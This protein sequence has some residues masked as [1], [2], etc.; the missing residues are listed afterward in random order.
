MLWVE[1]DGGGWGCGCFVA[2]WKVSREPD[3]DESAS[4]PKIRIGGDSGAISEIDRSST[5][6]AGAFRLLNAGA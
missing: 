5:E 3:H 2:H 6:G 1:D 4:T